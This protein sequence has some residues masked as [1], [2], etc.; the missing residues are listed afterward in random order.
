M[1]SALHDRPNEGSKARIAK[2]I[3]IGAAASALTTTTAA[4]HPAV[5][6]GAWIGK[7]I[8]IAMATV[9]AGALGTILVL[10]RHET[11]APAPVPPATTA[12]A[13][14]VPTVAQAGPVPATADPPTV[15]V[16]SLPRA[17]SARPTAT[18][19]TASARAAGS[20]TPSLSSELAALEDARA[21]LNA[22]KARD[23]L[24]KL[25]AYDREFPAGHLRDEAT[26][27][28]V[29]AL[30]RSGDPASAQA[31][32]ESFLAASP[33]SPYGTRVR[34]LLGAQ[35]TESPGNRP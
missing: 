33:S 8:R 15:D 6:S 17:P 10:S 21:S 9:T 22:G 4:A 13:E 16:G 32:A 24:A 29:E 31:L 2:A 34:S 20:D 14:V 1:R 18:L 26:V 30:I 23:A 12:T 5:A 3:G 35:G 11:A 19:P 28:R 25:D 27:L 7:W